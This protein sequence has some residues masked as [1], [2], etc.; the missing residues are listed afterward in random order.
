MQLYVQLLL[1]KFQRSLA[2]LSG[3]RL[4]TI[5]NILVRIG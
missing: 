2:E 1:S 3:G 5:Y 4:C